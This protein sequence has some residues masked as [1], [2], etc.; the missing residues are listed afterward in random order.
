MIIDI[1]KIKQEGLKSKEF[2][3]DYNVPDDLILSLPQASFN[4]V[5]NVSAFIELEG[6]DV[7]ADIT[8]NYQ[9]KGQCS[10]CLEKAIKDVNYC[11][12]AKFSLFPE[13]DEYLYKGGKVDLTDCVKEA[14]LLSQPSVIYCK[15]DCKGLCPICGAN[16]NVSDCGHK[17]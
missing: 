2:Q 1:V 6:R 16:L 8:L 13:E 15:D 12:N 7:F 17:F 10:R 5:C 4:G 14:I 9:I 3:F 11:F